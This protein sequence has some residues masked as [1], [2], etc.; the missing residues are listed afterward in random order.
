MDGKSIMGLL[1]LGASQGSI[2]T[3]SADGA[4]EQAALDTLT[5]LVSQGFEQ[6]SCA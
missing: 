3:L 4:D 5:R 2:I 1:L 6:A